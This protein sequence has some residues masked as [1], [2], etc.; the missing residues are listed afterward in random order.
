ML[1]QEIPAL[2]EQVCGTGGVFLNIF[3]WLTRLGKG[4][5][6]WFAGGL[7]VGGSLTGMLSALV[8]CSDTEGDYGVDGSCRTLG[9]ELSLSRE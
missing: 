6:P 8:A 4:W 7:F 1:F 9:W 5:K 2:E 3:G